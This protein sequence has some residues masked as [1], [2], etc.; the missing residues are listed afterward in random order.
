M[1][2]DDRARWW[3]DVCTAVVARG[4]AIR[5]AYAAIDPSPVCGLL[6]MACEL[7][8]GDTKAGRRPLDLRT[9]PTNGSDHAR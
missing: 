2:T 5:A 4:D 6:A 8:R 9:L 1:T 3:A 7:A